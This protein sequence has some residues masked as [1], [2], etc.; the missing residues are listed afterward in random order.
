LTKFKLKA[1]DPKCLSLNKQRYRSTL[2]PKT[3]DT[4]P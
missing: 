3:L 4:R 1:I 2:N